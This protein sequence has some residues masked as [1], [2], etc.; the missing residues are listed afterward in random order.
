MQSREQILWIKDPQAA[1]VA[2]GSGDFAGEVKL[3]GQ[4]SILASSVNKCDIVCATP[5]S[6]DVWTLTFE[7]VDFGDCNACGKAIGFGVKLKRHPDFDVE[8]YFDFPTQRIYLYDGIREGVVTGATIAANILAQ[9][10][11]LETQIDQHD[12]F[13]VSAQ[14]GANPDE[15]VL[16]YPCT[17]YT[18]YMVGIY[19]LENNN[20]ATAELPTFVHT[21]TGVEAVLSKEKLLKQYSMHIGHI[22][23]E[24]PRETFTWCEDTC[25]IS[26]KGCIDACSD[27]F[28]N[29]NSGHLHSASTRFDLLLYVNSGAPGFEDF[30]TAMNAAFTP[31]DMDTAPGYQSGV[32]IEVTAGSAVLPMDGFTFDAAGTVF[33]LTVGGVQLSLTATS[34]IT[35]RNAINAIFAGTA[36]FAA[37]PP[38]TLT[39]SGALAAQ[40]D[41]VTLTSPSWRNYTGE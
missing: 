41:F 28:D 13:F 11:E 9:M 25:A 14:A 22:P 2:V 24:A 4:I 19:Q 3:D 27:F 17:G 26:L 6:E 40:G 33:E 31:C 16:T 36:A 10:V 7:D 12:Q 32:Q 8:T 21:A 15:L 29:Q 5:C 35:L 30:I 1:T 37:G 20:L 39:I 38:S 34:G 18:T 23:G